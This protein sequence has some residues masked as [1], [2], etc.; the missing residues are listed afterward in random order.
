[1]NV[2]CTEQV[3]AGR[4]VR[5]RAQRA[6]AR[7]ARARFGVCVAERAPAS[8]RRRRGRRVRCIGA[9]SG[10]PRPQAPAHRRG[11]WPPRSTELP[12]KSSAS[13]RCRAR[14]R[15]RRGRAGRSGRRRPRGSPRRRVSMSPPRC[16][17]S[18]MSGDRLR[19]L[20]RI[21]HA[22][23]GGAVDEDAL[24][25]VAL[26]E[27]D[28]ARLVHLGVGIDRVA[29]PAA[30]REHERQRLLGVVVDE[31]ALLREARPRG[32]ARGCARCR[33][34]CR[35]AACGSSTGR[36]NSQRELELRREVLLLGRRLVVEADLARRRRRRPSRGSAAGARARRARRAG[37]SPPSGSGR[38]CRSGGCRTGSRGSAPSRGATRK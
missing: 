17:L 27:R 15:A 28:H 34:S 1:M 3:T 20:E 37:C 23:V 31:H 25:A 5:E 18:R 14:P 9:A 33:A 19:H 32:R 8:A 12:S 36:S 13:G 35:G 11:A 30:G 4:T 22:P 16:P 7:R 6:L 38:A 2:D 21:A 26:D 24:G 29:R 10:H